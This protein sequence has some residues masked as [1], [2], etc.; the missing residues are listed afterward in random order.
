MDTA[1]NDIAAMFTESCKE[2]I[3]HRRKRKSKEWIQQDTLDAIKERREIK[4]KLLQAK[5]PRIKER[6][7]DQY[8]E[9]HKKVKR[10]ARQNKRKAMEQLAQ[11]QRRQR[12]RGN[13]ESCTRSPNK[14]AASSRE[15][16]GDQSKTNR[17][18]C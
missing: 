5:S 2:K 15:A 7:V 18:N 6:L 4:K 11:R 12:Q 16:Q 13:K 3:G 8:R 1:W 9:T 17:E 14:S 10:L